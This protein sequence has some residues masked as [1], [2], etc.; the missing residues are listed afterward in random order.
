[1][2]NPNT[3]PPRDLLSPEF[4]RPVTHAI[5]FDVLTLFQNNFRLFASLVVLPTI[6]G[7]FFIWV[8]QSEIA[9]IRASMPSDM[10]SRLAAIRDTHILLKV[11]L[12]NLAGYLG[13]WLCWSFAFAAVTVAV[14]SF[15]EGRK[16][17]PEDCF[18]VIRE[19]PMAFLK[20]TVYLAV[21]ILLVFSL[22]TFGSVMALDAVMSHFNIRPEMLS[23]FYLLLGFVEVSL[24]AALVLPFLFAIPLS[25]T[26]EQGLIRS[27]KTSF[28]LTEG[29]SLVMLGLF[30]ETEASA[31]LIAFLI[32]WLIYRG[33]NGSGIPALYGGVFYLEVIITAFL[34][35]VAMIGFA[36]IYAIRSR[37]LAASELEHAKYAVSDSDAS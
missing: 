20:T 6:V 31:Y 21:K 1:M 15:L 9:R 35:P 27:L 7:T 8:A 25:I 11:S 30:V 33:P 24:V 16:V 2:S 3:I 26:G 4:D 12:I 32:R 34:Q 29:K 10:Q 28:S 5:I 37:E 13:S 19:R 14:A 22:I 36:W 17:D 23:P 18:N